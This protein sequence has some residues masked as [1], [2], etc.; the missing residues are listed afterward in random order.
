MKNFMPEEWEKEMNVEKEMTWEEK[1]TKKWY[2]HSLT[3]QGAFTTCG[4]EVIEFIKSLLKKQ[5]DLCAKRVE[6][7]LATDIY[8]YLGNLESVIKN[9]PEPKD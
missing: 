2:L 5:R 4:E 8:K 3:G 9:A 1:L 7:F 6:T